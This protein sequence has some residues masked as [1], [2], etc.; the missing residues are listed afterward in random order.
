MLVIVVGDSIDQNNFSAGPTAAVRQTGDV[1]N[2]GAGEVAAALAMDPRASLLAW[3]DPT[4]NA[5]L[6]GN[7]PRFYSGGALGRA[8]AVSSDIIAEIPRAAAYLGNLPGL[9]ILG[10]GTNYLGRSDEAFRAMKLKEIDAFH[11]AL[12]HV[13]LGVC[14]VRAVGPSQA[15][16][17]GRTAINI[18][19]KNAQI[20]AA[21][22]ERSSFCSLIDLS[23][24]ADDPEHPGQSRE[25]NFA[26]NPYQPSAGGDDLHPGLYGVSQKGGPAVAAF[27]RSHVTPGNALL[28][29]RVAGI[30]P[31]SVRFF[32]GTV[33]I[34]RKSRAGGGTVL[35]FVAAQMDVSPGT[36]NVSNAVCSLEANGETGEQCQVLTIFPSGSATKEVWNIRPSPAEVATASLRNAWSRTWFEIEV[37][38]WEGWLNVTVSNGEMSDLEAHRQSG[39]FGVFPLGSGMR[40]LYP[41]T[42][43]LLY[44]ADSSG[45]APTLA[46]YCNPSAGGGPGVLKIRQWDVQ[47][48]ASP[49]R[50]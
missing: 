45:C 37:D 15:G 36:N 43:H 39:Q 1:M 30:I 41:H 2:I 22:A 42:P 16:Q 23:A 29:R 11:A 10:G 9:G 35:G 24:Y 44:G 20:A 47:I 6:Y 40:R 3:N 7:T 27:I 14:T 25:I 21:V 13:P 19:A 48:E 46:V 32:S 28:T 26:T 12:P 18:A 49:V 50:P 34:S 31:P 8:G 33:P 5:A 4:D 17:N 38:Q